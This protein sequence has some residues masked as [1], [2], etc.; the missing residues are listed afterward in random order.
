MSEV[1][2]IKI[3][4]KN[5]KL[6]AQYSS[7]NKRW[8]IKNNN[9]NRQEFKIR[10][11]NIINEAFSKNLFNGSS[12]GNKINL[13]SNY[14]IEIS[15]Y[16]GIS[17]KSNPISSFT[18]SDL[19]NHINRLFLSNDEQFKQLLFFIQLTLN[20]T[21]DG[22]VLNES[23]AEKFAEAMKIS[24]IHA[25]I[26]FIDGLYQIYPLNTEFIDEPLVI[27]VLK[28]LDSY[29]NVKKYYLEA[30]Q[31]ERNESNNR[32]IVD[33]LR[34]TLEKFFQKFFNNKKTLENQLSNI[35]NYLKRNNISTHIS[36]TYE[37][38]VEYYAKYN[39]DNAK[40]G[41]NINSVEIDFLIYLTGSFIRFFVLIL[42]E[43]KKI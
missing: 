29:P 27:D 11:L 1:R 7:F 21:Y 42:E 26:L 25:K 2:E 32:H 17:T 36:N 18:N 15:S 12:L 20:Y 24:N 37:K 23:L 19:Y 6:F 30:I 5:S 34:L 10:C 38:L 9:D 4:E 33:D 3:N 35:G 16:L 14:C 39:D 28:W 8:D 40:H 31:T 13:I 22:T 41:D 43:S